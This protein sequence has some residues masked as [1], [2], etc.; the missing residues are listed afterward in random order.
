M[1]PTEQAR[2]D[3][4]NRQVSVIQ[5]YSNGLMS[6]RTAIEQLGFVDDVGEEIKRLNREKGKRS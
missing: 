1:K 6:R 3:E 4:L 5:Q 2:Q